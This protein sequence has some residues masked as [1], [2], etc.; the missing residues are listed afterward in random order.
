MLFYGYVDKTVVVIIK[1]NVE[2]KRG[3]PTEAQAAVV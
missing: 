1:D 2:G 3:T